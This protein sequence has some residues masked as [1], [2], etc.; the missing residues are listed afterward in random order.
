MQTLTTAKADSEACRYITALIY[1]RCG[2]RLHDGKDAL[3]KARLGKRMRHFGFTCLAEYC[4]FL[5]SDDHE[6]EL[7]RMTD[8]LTT[9][10]TSF[11]REEIHFKFMV[12]EALPALLSPGST[13]IRV[14]SAASA[15]GEEPYSIAFYLHD[16]YPAAEGWDWRITASDI[17]TKVL[18][19]GR[20]GIYAEERVQGLPREWLRQYFQKG[21]GQWAGSYRVK[22]SLSERVAFRQINLIEAYHHPQPF[23]IIFCR[24]VMIY[25]DRDTQERLVRQLCR[26]LSPQGYL[27][28]GH[29]ES[30]N[31]LD[32]PVRCVRPSIYQRSAA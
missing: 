8:A 24:N 31:G 16:R 12:D 10:F 28:I 13:K 25:F 32:V 29:S 3:I 9:N 22:S 5:Q 14:W 15:S 11:L 17:S 2:I 19:K 18:E 26:F 20:Q 27:L 30:L 7:E 23:Q 4:D 21:V 6:E 1:Q